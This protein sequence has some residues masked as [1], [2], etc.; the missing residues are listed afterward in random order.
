[1]LTLYSRG[2]HR[3]IY[4]RRSESRFDADCCREAQE[5][6]SIDLTGRDTSFERN[7]KTPLLAF[8]PHGAVPFTS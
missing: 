8:E 6:P 7:Q 5:P 2:G 1:M 4:Q 3:L